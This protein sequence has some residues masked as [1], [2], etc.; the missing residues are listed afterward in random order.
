MFPALT[1]ENLARFRSLYTRLAPDYP[2]SVLLDS[3]GWQ[4]KTGGFYLM[5]FEAQRVIQ[6]QGQQLLV[7][8]RP[9]KRVEDAA[10]LWMS[11]ESLFRQ[12]HP[13]LE[14][15][16]IYRGFRQGWVGALG[17]ELNALLEPSLAARACQN[18]MGEAYWV[19]FRHRICWLPDEGVFDILSPDPHWVARV[20][21]MV[22]EVEQLSDAALLHPQ[23]SQETRPP[24]GEPQVS[25]TPEAFAQ[26][27]MQI[28]EHIRQ[29]N[30]YQANLSLR[31]SVADVSP[32]QLMPLYHALVTQNPSPFSGVFWTPEGV[33]V[34]NSPERL[35]KADAQTQ[36]VEARPIAGTRGRGKTEAEDQAIAHTLNTDVKEQ[37]EHLM[38]VDLER[39]DLGRVCVA[40]SVHV[41]ELAVLERYSHVTHIVSQVEGE[42][43]P[44]VTPWQILD[45][46]FPG[47]TITGCPKIRC[48]RILHDLEPVPRGFYTGGLGYIDVSGNLDVNILIR[49]LFHWPNG[50]LH[51]H[52]GA[53]IVADSVPVWEYRECLRKAQV[54]QGVLRHHDHLTGTP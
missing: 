21:A 37:A 22:A 24:V 39:N 4:G 33:I 17:Y 44:E 54:I 15:P 45:A 31:F 13:T 2:H 25:M 42:K 20:K 36:I 30:L 38:L 50:Q 41:P 28:Q 52:A 6:L 53:G 18:P 34:S 8:G 46:L 40:G 19:D 11:L 43:R 23:W 51:Y 29:G 27:V 47:G 14:E 16:P 10:S 9:W 48:M 26:G 5:G 1:P 49:S 12:S 3:C 7:N 35:V 32:S